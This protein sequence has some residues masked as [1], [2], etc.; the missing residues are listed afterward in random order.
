MDLCLHPRVVEAVKN[1]LGSNIVLL[2]SAIFTKYPTKK[3]TE[4]FSGDFVGW[5]QDMKYWGLVNLK[6]K[7]RIKLASMWLAIDKVHM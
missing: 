7:D 3:K 1:L 5:H 6:R 4:T 2:S